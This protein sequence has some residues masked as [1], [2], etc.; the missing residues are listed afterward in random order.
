MD[1]DVSVSFLLPGLPLTEG[2]NEV[3]AQTFPHIIQLVGH[4][5]LRA[6]LIASF[7]LHISELEN[8]LQPRREQRARVDRNRA[9]RPSQGSGSMKPR[10]FMRRGHFTSDTVVQSNSCISRRNEVKFFHPSSSRRRCVRESKEQ[11]SAHFISAS[12]RIGINF[13]VPRKTVISAPFSDGSG[14]ARARLRQG[15]VAP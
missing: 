7:A 6:K 9:L 4:V 11:S 3:Y 15:V 8:A 1:G 10:V 12:Q 14:I 2:I 13:L 5:C